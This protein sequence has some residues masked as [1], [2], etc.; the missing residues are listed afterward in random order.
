[1]SP[2]IGTGGRDISI[3]L[4]RISFY[5]IFLARKKMSCVLLYMDM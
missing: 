1:M 4:D 3:V 5:L 2:R